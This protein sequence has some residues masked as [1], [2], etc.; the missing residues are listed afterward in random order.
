MAS[1][2][3]GDTQPNLTNDP[4]KGHNIF[5]ILKFIFPMGLGGILTTITIIIFSAS[6]GCTIKRHPNTGS[7]E[8]IECKNS[9]P[10]KP[11]NQFDENKKQR[12]TTAS[13][14]DIRNALEPENPESITLAIGEFSHNIPH[15]TEFIKHKNTEE[16]FIK[17]PVLSYGILTDP[18]NYENY[19]TAIR[20][21]IESTKKFKIRV[22]SLDFDKT[23]H[24]NQEES[25][26]EKFYNQGIFG[27][28]NEKDLDDYLDEYLIFR[29]ASEKP[30]DHEDALKILLNFEI[31]NH[32]LIEKDKYKGCH[33]PLYSEPE[34]F[35]WASNKAAIFALPN[36]KEEEKSFSIFTTNHALV[37]FLKNYAK[38]G[39]C[40]V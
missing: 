22:A 3:S 31:G 7:V 6:T 1:P 29:N 17:K 30:E 14:I 20:Q 8:G 37:N 32:S 16:L 10:I 4:P 13:V 27:K 23:S 11:S 24:P 28:K 40:Q 34:L 21:R 19:I 5:N 38:E 9:S 12:L 26:F 25:A 33:Q 36:T 2:Q 18:D 39:N 35:V 15:I